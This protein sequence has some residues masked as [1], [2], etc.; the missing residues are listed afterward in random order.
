VGVGTALAC[1]MRIAAEGSKFGIP[2][3][4]LGLG[5]AYDGIKK[6]IDLVG[7]A[8]AREIFLYPRASSP[9]KRRCAWASSTSLCR[10]A[11]WRLTSTIIAR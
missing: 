2:A 11:S 9:P 4:K 10:T 7:S 8:H 5:Y 3:A 6:L 1:D